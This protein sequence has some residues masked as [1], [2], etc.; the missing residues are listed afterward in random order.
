MT[1]ILV[2]LR[3]HYCYAFAAEVASI[4]VVSMSTPRTSV[5]HLWCFV[6]VYGGAAATFCDKYCSYVNVAPGE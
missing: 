6:S 4:C 2:Q 5:Q 1:D 3:C